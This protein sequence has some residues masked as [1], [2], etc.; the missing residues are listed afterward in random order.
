MSTSACLRTRF[1]RDSSF[2]DLIGKR[3][4][5][6]YADCAACRDS[7]VFFVSRSCQQQAVWKTLCK[8]A[9]NAGGRHAAREASDGEKGYGEDTR[10]G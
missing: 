8:S 1:F 6:D 5:Y 9:V 4:K 3:L 7:I 10:I 2:F